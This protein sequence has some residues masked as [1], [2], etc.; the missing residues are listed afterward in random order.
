MRAGGVAGALAGAVAYLIGSGIPAPSCRRACAWRARHRRR[1]L[2]RG[3]AYGREESRGRHESEFNHT[4]HP[5]EV[6]LP[7]LFALRAA[8][9]L[10]SRRPVPVSNFARPISPNQ[11][12]QTHQADEPQPAPIPVVV[13]IAGIG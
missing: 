11:T 7:K 9:A 13:T 2:S 3:A 6:W 5:Y 4:K 10:L 1:A 8:P 12:G